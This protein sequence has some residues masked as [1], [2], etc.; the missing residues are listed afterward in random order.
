MSEM[1]FSIKKYTPITI[2]KQAKIVC[3]IEFLT[4]SANT[5]QMA[6]IKTEGTQTQSTT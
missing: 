1:R 2:T 6:E 3:K 5:V 4:L